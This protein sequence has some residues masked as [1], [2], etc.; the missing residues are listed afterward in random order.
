MPLIGHNITTDDN[1]PSMIIDQS[2]NVVCIT[3]FTRKALCAPG[4]GVLVLVPPVAR[5]FTCKALI[6]NDRHFSATS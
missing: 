5:S 6:P 3:T 1:D 2:S 4:P